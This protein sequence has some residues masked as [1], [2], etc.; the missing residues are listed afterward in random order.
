M[1]YYYDLS[2]LIKLK[3][4][5]KFFVQINENTT[6]ITFARNKQSA[7]KKALNYAKKNNLIKF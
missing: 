6:V 5:Q 7:L 3:N 1:Y 2:E 4:P